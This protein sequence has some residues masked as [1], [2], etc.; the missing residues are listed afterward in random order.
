MSLNTYYRYIQQYYVKCDK[1][2]MKTRTRITH[3]SIG[4]N[5]GAMLGS[6]IVPTDKKKEHYELYARSVLNGE[7]LYMNEFLLS[8]KTG[9]T[10]RNMKVKIDLDFKTKQHG[11]ATR[12]FSKEKV[13][14]FVIKYNNIL[15][16]YLDVKL[17]QIEA[18]V[19]MRPK[20]YSL[21]GYFK[22]GIHIMYPKIICDTV[23]QKYI[24][25]EMLEHIVTLCEG[26][27]FADG[28]SYKDVYDEQP[29]TSPEWLLYGSTKDKPAGLNPHQLTYIVLHDGTVLDHM[30]DMN[31]KTLQSEYRDIFP[32]LEDFND[33]L[34]YIK[35]LSI[36]LLN[37]K[38]RVFP[39]EK[40]VKLFKTTPK[41]LMS[42]ISINT[43]H[44]AVAEP[45]DVKTSPSTLTLPT[46]LS[47]DSLCSR[48]SSRNMTNME[49]TNI[50]D[51]N[52]LVSMFS[53]ERASNY[54]KWVNVGICLKNI[55]EMFLPT[56]IKFSQRCSEKYNYDVCVDYWE[57]KFRT[58]NRTNFLG[59]A[60]IYHWAQT[61]NLKE[62]TKFKN[63]HVFERIHNAV[64]VPSHT[65]IADIL[66]HLTHERFICD[67][68]KKDSWFE[69]M[70]HRWIAT[71]GVGIVKAINNDLSSA[72]RSYAR[73]L[74]DKFEPEKDDGDHSH[75]MSAFA[76][77]QQK[78]YE[79]LGVKFLGNFDFKTKVK[80]E[81]TVKYYNREFQELLDENRRLIGFTNG[82]FD[83]D[84][85]EFRDGYPHD[86]ISLST[87]Y[88]YVPIDE[89]DPM[90]N[91]ID[92]YMSQVFTDVNLREYVWKLSGSLLEGGN[93]MAIFPIF[94]GGGANSKSLFVK[95]LVLVLGGYSM[96]MSIS[97]L[98]NKRGKQNDT[99]PEL[100]KA[101]G[102]RFI[103]L[104]ETDE[105]NELNI[106]IMKEW[107]S[108]LDEINVRTLYKE[109]ITFYPQFILC[110]LCNK[111]PKIKGDDDGT[112]RRI[113]VV[114]FNSKFC[115]NP[116]PANPNEFIMDNRLN[117]RLP[118]WRDAFLH[119]LLQYYFKYRDEGIVEPSIVTEASR[120]YRLR[121]DIIGDFVKD[122]I[123]DNVNDNSHT[124]WHRIYNVYIDWL[125][126][127][128]G[129]QIRPM[130]S[131]EFTICVK[132]KLDSHNIVYSVKGTRVNGFDVVL[133]TD[134]DFD[135]L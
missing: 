93:E 21:N 69:Y 90:L 30:C 56:W 75:E 42:S 14:D 124:T 77:Q 36:R 83:L 128:Y 68:I 24:R 64:I 29:I 118:L 104:D 115:E 135:M 127:N 47:K 57:K 117:E 129:D 40:Y 121:N 54:F 46:I 61:D 103:H 25:N 15:M 20:P 96:K 99:N 94:T 71:E 43:K 62:Y 23:I 73:T 35:L 114:P 98:T 78:V 123:K 84:T 28:F 119:R 85:R 8:E 13:I 55:N 126:R 17:E 101:K 4:T 60:S 113:R 109:P 44:N 102:R 58:R 76:T 31:D 3:T 122:T 72:I 41:S 108:G 9:V 65:I 59:I 19:T 1:K 89:G 7:R 116:N 132:S 91:E 2:D 131:K 34:K 92:N 37:K 26:I 81:A 51:I 6:F 120:E 112:W 50:D 32:N 133:D 38:Y 130:N 125:S 39:K 105:D 97:Q 63:D 88:D 66:Y 48:S 52:T 67:C 70:D 27:P 5:N 110:L 79:L 53:D 80:K 45:D 134:D 100:A 107:T 12:L 95:L 16:K 106:G 74:D 33:L 11:G 111:L 22:D 10:P 87:G 49:Q 82:V 86:F 18:H